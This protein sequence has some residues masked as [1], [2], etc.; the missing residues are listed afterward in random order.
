MTASGPGPSTIP[1]VP[2]NNGRSMPQVGLGTW[3]L[4]DEQAA[5][6][7]REA[8]VAGYRSFDTAE[9]Y[10]N[11]QGVGAGLAATGLSR[12]ELFVTT[13]LDGKFQGHD[14]ALVG[15]QDS[16][17]RLQLDHVDLLLIHWP[18]P[19]RDQYVNTW[20]T[21]EKALADGLTNAIGVSNFKMAHLHRLLAE[22]DV[23]PAVNQVQ[24]SPYSAREQIR[25][26][27]RDHGI[28]T[29]SWSPLGAGSDL[30]G[31]SVLTDIAGRI[32]RSPAQVV[33]RWHVQLGLAV[34]PKSS[35][36]DRLRENIDLFDFHLTDEQMQAIATL[37]QGESAARDSDL[38]GH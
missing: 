1:L 7:V 35:N 11:E 20:R 18:L 31:S 19:A 33:L 6:A 16:L 36:P 34:I 21:F 37:D 3:P 25:S 2:L 17:R 5:A 24:L 27:D 14:R 22:T 8:A 23:I 9:K 32:G 15:V 13:K 12:D 10:G 38:E 30:L 26:F 29:Q 28:V 4:N